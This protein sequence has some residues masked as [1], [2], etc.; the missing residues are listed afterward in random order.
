LRRTAGFGT[1]DD[2]SHKNVENVQAHSC[3]DYREVG[4]VKYPFE[5]KFSWLDGR[6]A[7]KLSDV[8]VNV[9]ID[10]ARFGRPSR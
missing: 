10:A 8:K 7:A 2:N 4:G 9:Q 3:A 1:G 6:Y 5:Y